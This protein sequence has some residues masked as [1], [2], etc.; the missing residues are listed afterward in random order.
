MNI[1]VIYNIHYKY[2]KNSKSSSSQAQVIQNLIQPKPKFSLSY[3]IN[4]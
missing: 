1:I 4:K 2:Y 3:K